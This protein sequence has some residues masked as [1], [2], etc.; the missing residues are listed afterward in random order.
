MW[1]YLSTFSHEFFTTTPL[2]PKPI[3]GQRSEVRIIECK[4][5]EGRISGKVVQG[6]TRNFAT[7]SFT[8]PVSVARFTVSASGGGI[9][10]I[11]SSAS[12][13]LRRPYTDPGKGTVVYRSYRQEATLDFT[14][15]SLTITGAPA[16]W[17][18]FAAKGRSRIEIGQNPGMLV[19]E[20]DSDWS[21]GKDCRGR[22]G[23]R[24]VLPVENA[25]QGEGHGGYLRGS[26]STGGCSPRGSAE[27]RLWAAS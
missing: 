10:A 21:P 11:T 12:Q 23:F 25:A 22:T 9:P 3:L 13:K 4:Q 20:H 6:R 26:P 2:K 8:C 5:L 14:Y 24:P 27:A 1:L 18:A 17:R 16:G 15:V 19:R 7:A